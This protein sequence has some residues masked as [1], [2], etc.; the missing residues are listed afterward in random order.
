MQLRHR[1]PRSLPCSSAAQVAILVALVVLAVALAPTGGLAAPG[2]PPGSLEHEVR[3]ADP[4]S[5]DG[6]LTE[7]V[8]FVAASLPALLVGRSSIV[9]LGEVWEAPWRW[10]VRHVVQIVVARGGLI[11]YGGH[12]PRP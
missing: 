2:Q 12:P 10:L 7:T 8:L 6:V 5:P 9:A 1:R 4:A 3:H 11:H